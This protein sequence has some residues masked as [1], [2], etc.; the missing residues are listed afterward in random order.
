MSVLRVAQTEMSALRNQKSKMKNILVT[1][2]HRS[3][4]TWTGMV[5]ASGGE[6]LYIQEPFNVLHKKRYE[7]PVE[8]WFEYIDN[9]DSLARQTDFKQ[10]LHRFTNFDFS[11]LKED[12]N[13]TKKITQYPR[14]VY[15]AFRKNRVPRKL[16]KDPLALF[17]AE[18]LAEH[19]DM[20][21]V[22]L[23]RHPAAFAE[24]IQAR[25]MRHDFSHFLEQENLMQKHLAPFRADIEDF[26]QNPIRQADIF[27]HAT[28]LWNI[29]HH[30]ILYYKKKYPNWIFVRHEDLSRTPFETFG[31]LF[32]DLNLNFNEKAKKYLQDT[33]QSN[34]N[35]RLKRQSAANIFKWKKNLTPQQ[36]QFIYDKTQHISKHF[37]TP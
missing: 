9:E 1:G 20:D 14:T 34:E 29:I 2:S 24:S 12:L 16:I 28:L 23:V 26:I 22:V 18:W 19:F 32:D 4:S 37:Y 27:E 15:G 31:K 11:R 33:T 5:L 17:S 13:V 6:V 35:S 21:V 8:Y 25:D 3:G 36:Q 7:T 10:Y 30:Q